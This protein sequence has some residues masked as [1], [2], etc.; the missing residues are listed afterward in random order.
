MRSIKCSSI[1][2]AIATE[3]RSI[4]FYWKFD[5]VKSFLVVVKS[6]EVMWSL[7][8]FIFLVVEPEEP[9]SLLF[10]GDHSK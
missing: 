8:T 5:T 10:T 9:Y 1:D 3:R 2:T 6:F 7:Y 4:T